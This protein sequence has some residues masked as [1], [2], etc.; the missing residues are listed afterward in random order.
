VPTPQ[1]LTLP[2]GWVG[3]TGGVGNSCTESWKGRPKGD[4]GGP[5]PEG[6]PDGHLSEC[7][8]KNTDPLLEDAFAGLEAPQT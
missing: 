1:Q 2:W 8:V 6:L 4:S 7:L 5:R 3:E